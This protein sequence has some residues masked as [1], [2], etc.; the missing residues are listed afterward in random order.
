M[1]S[2]IADAPLEI[3]KCLPGISEAVDEFT[4]L[5]VSSFQTTDAFEVMVRFEPS[6]RLMVIV[7]ALRALQSDRLVSE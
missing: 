7:S 1:L 2:E 5:K 3:L 4:S 6:D